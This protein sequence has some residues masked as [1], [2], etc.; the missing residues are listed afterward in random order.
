MP[1]TLARRICSGSG[2][3]RTAA[4]WI[5]VE[6]PATASG[7]VDGSRRSPATDETPSGRGLPGRT[8]ARQS[9]PSSTRRG[10]RR[11]PTSPVAPVMRI[12]MM[13]SL[14]KGVPGA[15]QWRCGARGRWFPRQTLRCRRTRC[16]GS[17][18]S[19]R[20]TPATTPHRPE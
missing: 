4:R 3:R 13:V 18:L 19:G 9:Y 11:L 8:R 6:I 15:C 1:S 10:M 14:S 20:A 2:F 7:S 12:V 17:G 5:T 16:T